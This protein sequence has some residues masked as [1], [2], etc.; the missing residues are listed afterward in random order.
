[1]SGSHRSSSA[2]NLSDN[3]MGLQSAGSEGTLS[4]AS[5]TSPSAGSRDPTTPRGGKMSVGS[6]VVTSGSSRS[7]INRAFN[8]FLL[9]KPKSMVSVDAIDADPAGNS[10]GLY[11]NNSLSNPGLATSSIFSV[12]FL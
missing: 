5:T 6:G 10:G 9:H 11:P 7:R 2:S 12:S 8:R 1:M 3:L 4:I